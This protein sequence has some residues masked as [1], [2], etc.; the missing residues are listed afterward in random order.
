MSGTWNKFFFSILSKLQEVWPVYEKYK[1]KSWPS[2]LPL[3]PLLNLEESLFSMKAPLSELGLAPMMW[4]FINYN[5]WPV[6]YATLHPQELL[7]GL[8]VS[9]LMAHAKRWYCGNEIT[10]SG[11]RV[12]HSSNFFLNT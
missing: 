11:E 9:I 5:G 7:A 4:A 12:K 6:K 1:N 2:C 10:A 8:L 3:L